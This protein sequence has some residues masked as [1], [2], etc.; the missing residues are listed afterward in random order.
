MSILFM[1]TADADFYY[2]MLTE[3]SKTVRKYCQ[4]NGFQYNQYVGVKSGNMPWKATY[5]RIIMLKELLDAGFLGWV[6]YLDADAYISD[7]RFD[8]MDYLHDKHGS[9]GIFCGYLHGVPHNINAGGF[10]INF[11]HPVGRSMVLDYYKIFADL[12]REKFDNAMH[13]GAEVPE[14]QHLL[15]VVIKSYLQ[16]RGISES[17]IFEHHS[18]CYVNNGPFIKQALR[19]NFSSFSERLDEVRRRVALAIGDGQDVKLGE[20][21]GVAYFY[22]SSVRLQ[23][24]VGAKTDFGILTDGT[25]AGVLLFGPYINLTAGQYVARLFGRVVNCDSKDLTYFFECAVTTENGKNHLLD[26]KLPVTKVGHFVADIA[27]EVVDFAR[28][29]EIKVV[30]QGGVKALIHTLKIEICTGTW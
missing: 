18:N 23:T 22:S 21:A 11:S 13:W 8:L 19:V 29:L 6:F 25:E 12:N 9:A 15:E 2:D 10:A 1:Q 24:A 4:L 16:Y 27:F 26:T 5:N 3:T 20:S 17:L 28:N 30:S 14:D 7:L